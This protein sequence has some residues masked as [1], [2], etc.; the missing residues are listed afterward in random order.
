MKSPSNEPSR[1]GTPSSFASSRNRR[2]NRLCSRLLHTL[3][4]ELGGRRKPREITVRLS[5]PHV[6]RGK[7]VPKLSQKRSN[8]FDWTETVRRGIS[9][10]APDGRGA[11]MSTCFFRGKAETGAR[12]G[13]KMELSHDLTHNTLMMKSQSKSYN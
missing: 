1:A 2:H 6:S 5:A 4:L 7:L 13:E 10:T 12:L 3:F 8:P 11:K 9:E